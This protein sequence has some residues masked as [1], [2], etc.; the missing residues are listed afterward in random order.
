M[1]KGVSR[2]SVEFFCLKVPK[3]FV[4]EP[5]CAVFR[6]FPISKKFWITGGVSRFSVESFRSQSA[7]IFRSGTPYCF[8]NFGYRKMMRINR[9][10]FWQGSGSNPKPTA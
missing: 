9:E 2:L 6:K 5:F 1:R 8:S 4:R 10:I 3:N 7:E